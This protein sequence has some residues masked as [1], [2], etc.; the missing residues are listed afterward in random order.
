MKFL[1]IF[2]IFNSFSVEMS[3]FI[4]FEDKKV[5]LS[6]IIEITLSLLCNLPLTP[7]KSPLRQYCDVV[8]AMPFHIATGKKSVSYSPLAFLNGLWTASVIFDTFPFQFL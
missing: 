1:Y 4:D 3:S 7:I 2:Y 5:I 6:A 8:S